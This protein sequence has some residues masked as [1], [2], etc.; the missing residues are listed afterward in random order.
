M[1]IYKTSL[2]RD[3][4]I[5]FTIYMCEKTG[6]SWAWIVTEGVVKGARYIEQYITYHIIEGIKCMVVS[7]VHS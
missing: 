2:E 3:L 6:L 1:S 5:K 7:G 4:E